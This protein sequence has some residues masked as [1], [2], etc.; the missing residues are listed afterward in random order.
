MFGLLQPLKQNEVLLV[1][2][3]NKLFRRSHPR[4]LSLL[5]IDILLRSSSLMLLSMVL[6]LREL[7]ILGRE[8]LLHHLEGLGQLLPICRELQDFGFVLANFAC[9]VFQLSSHF[10]VVFFESDPQLFHLQSSLLHS[11]FFGLSGDVL[12]LSQLLFHLRRLLFKC[13]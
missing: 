8:F 5:R 3:S 9:S 12:G 4:S 1:L 6:S 10:L 2:V 11:G 13:L 7:V